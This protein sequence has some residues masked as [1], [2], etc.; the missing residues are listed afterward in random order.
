[1]ISHERKTLYKVKAILSFV[2]WHGPNVP[3]MKKE[4]QAFAQRLM[5]ALAVTGIEA[6]PA[7][8]ERLLARHGGTPVMP[9]AISGWLTGKH[10]PTL[11]MGCALRGAANCPGLGREQ[12][13]RRAW[14]LLVLQ[15]T[16]HCHSVYR[17]RLSPPRYAGRD[18]QAHPVRDALSARPPKAF[19]HRVRSTG[20]SD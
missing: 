12:R 15:R 3:A 11:A 4:Q 17:T 18:I 2:I 14:L 1:M 13:V 9:Q 16:S 10:L 5:E 20:W 19:A 6:S 8:L 7:E